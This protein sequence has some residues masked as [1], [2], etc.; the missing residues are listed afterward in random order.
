MTAIARKPSMSVRYFGLSVKLRTDPGLSDFVLEF[1][2]IKVST[3]EDIEKTNKPGFHDK[4]FYGLPGLMT[5][6]KK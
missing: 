5:Q 6:G 1:T 2:T 4:P 3:A